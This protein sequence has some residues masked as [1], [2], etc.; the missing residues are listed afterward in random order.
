MVTRDDTVDIAK[1]ANSAREEVSSAVPHITLYRDNRLGYNS[2]VPFV[3]MIHMAVQCSMKYYRRRRVRR[4]HF[5]SACQTLRE[6]ASAADADKHA[7][8]CHE[9]VVHGYKNIKRLVL[10]IVRQRSYVTSKKFEFFS[11]DFFS[12]DLIE[13]GVFEVRFQTFPPDARTNR[14]WWLPWKT[15]SDEEPTWRCS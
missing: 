10:Y 11:P 5:L 12:L 4:H 6:A 2:T 13:I 14:D 3:M 1:T 7:L 9:T 8:R 15:P